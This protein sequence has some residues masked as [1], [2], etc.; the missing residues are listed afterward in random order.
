MKNNINLSVGLYS[1]LGNIF[2]FVIKLL[3]VIFTGSFG[4]IADMMNSASDILSSFMVYIG[5]KI[6]MKD[7]DADHHMGH[8]KAEYIF[9]LLISVLM[10]YLSFEVIINAIK[11]LFERRTMNF[12]PYL[13]FVCVATIIVK[14]CLYFYSQ[15]VYKS[16]N[17]ILVATSSIDHRNDCFLTSIN[18]ISFICFNFGFTYFD[19]IS[20]IVI[21]LWIFYS[22]CGLFKS[23]YD[24][25]MDKAMSEDTVCR[26]LSIINKY[27]EVAKVN[28]FNTTPVGYRY[29]I[30]F[31]IFVDGNIS[32]FDSHEIA[33]NLEKEI[34][35]C[36]PEVYLVI[37]HVN[38]L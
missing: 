3:V 15:R 9:S 27:S 1:I 14:L 22:A 12:S 6:S 23:S 35:K 33:N 24:V 5:N 16:T 7:A 28:H 4:M 18:L 19:I 37:I 30:S 34:C 29:Q 10:M 13:I 36:I 8:G 32:T 21:S 17:N 31:T 38:P 26:V 11:S 20:G 2:L 25:L